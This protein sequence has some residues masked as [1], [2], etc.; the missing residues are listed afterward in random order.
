MEVQMYEPFQNFLSNGAGLAVCN[1]TCSLVPA[2]FGPFA[3][4]ANGNTQDTVLFGDS[5]IASGAKDF[6]VDLNL[7]SFATG[8]AACYLSE[9]GFNDCVSWGTFSN[10]SALTTNFGSSAD[11]GTPAAALTSGMALRRS[12]APGCPTMLEASDDTNNS[13]ADFSLT[14]RDPRTNAVAPTETP[15]AGGGGPTG[16][17]PATTY[18]TAKKKCKKHKKSSAY[19]AKK[20]KCKKKRK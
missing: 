4:V 5:G 10:N 19:S 2:T 9:A 12:I 20:K 8:G 6:N 18:P 11:P 7:D 1:P 17:P 15:C 16:Y 14:T 3:D 13:A